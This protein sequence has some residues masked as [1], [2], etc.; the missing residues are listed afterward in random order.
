MLWAG[1]NVAVRDEPNWID[2]GGVTTYLP[3]RDLTGIHLTPRG[4]PSELATPSGLL[5][6]R[7]ERR[8]WIRQGRGTGDFENY[9]ADLGWDPALVH[10]ADLEL[11]HEEFIAGE[12]VLATRIRLEDIDTGVVEG[13]GSC[14]VALPTLGRKVAHG[15]TLYTLEG[16]FL[17]RNGPYPLIERIEMRPTINGE[18]L[19]PIVTGVTEPPP[20]LEAR[21][22]RTERISQDLESLV[23]NATQARMIS[24]REAA[25]TRLR[26]LINRARRELLIIDRYFGQDVEDWRLLDHVKVPVRV[27]TGKIS[28]DVARIPPHVQ[29]RFRRRAPLH[30]RVYVW[31]KGGL[32][33]G[34]SPTTFGQGPVRITRLPIPEAVEWQELF[35]SLWNSPLFQEVP[36]V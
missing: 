14:S 9:L 32:S 30:E 8:A 24:D 21:I 19:P 11:T 25:L 7:A 5:V 1:P 12:L 36:R 10:L 22:D 27:L 20:G 6:G 33:V 2:V 26:D 23:K 35:E 16:E 34:G 17:D 4:T 29:A 18:E 3:S 31:D 13:S 15:L 28:D